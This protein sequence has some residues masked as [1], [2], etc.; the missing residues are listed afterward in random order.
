MFDDAYPHHSFC[1]VFGEGARL[2]SHRYTPHSRSPVFNLIPLK[3]SQEVGDNL[4]GS[5]GY[6]KH[7]LLSFNLVLS[8]STLDPTFCPCY[9]A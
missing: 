8:P 5:G 4:M 3:L 2:H 1:S 9:Q 7:E 6:L